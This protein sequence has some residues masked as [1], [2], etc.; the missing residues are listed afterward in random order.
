[1]M[2]KI[3]KKGMVLISVYLVAV[4]CTFLVTNR[5]QE[6]DSNSHLRNTNKALSINLAR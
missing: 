6:L 2:M 1:M 5:V 4:V 3:V